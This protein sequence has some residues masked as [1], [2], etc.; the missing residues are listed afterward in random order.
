M[1]EVL[2]DVLERETIIRIDD[3]KQRFSRER[4][5]VSGIQTAKNLIMRRVEEIIMKVSSPV[6]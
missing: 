5:Q 1:T 4:M 3:Q 2:M 6:N